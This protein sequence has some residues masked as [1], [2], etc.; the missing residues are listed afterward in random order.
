MRKI[1]YI[2]LLTS[3]LFLSGCATH[4]HKDFLQ[5]FTKSQKTDGSRPRVV[6]SLVY[7]EKEKLLL[8]G[9]E[10]GSIEIWDA[11]KSLSMR[12]IKAHDYRANLLAFS[13][14]G[15]AFFSNSYFE[16]VTKLWDVQSGELICSIPNTRGPVSITSDKRFHVI[17]NGD[18]LRIFDSGINTLLAESYKFPFYT[19][20]AIAY[21]ISTDQVAI[22]TDSGEIQ[23]LRF[24]VIKG[25]PT[26][27]KVSNAKP[28]PMGNWVVG[29][30]FSKS[31]R[32]L[33]SVARFGS[34]DEWSTQPFKIKRSLPIVLKNVH[35]VAFMP[36]KG[37]LALSGTE[38]QVFPGTDF[39]FVKV[40]PL[41]GGIPSTFKMSMKYPGTIE[42]LPPLASVLSAES[43][44][45]EVY[46]LPR[47]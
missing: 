43:Y 39:G 12:E 36:S 19:I 7:N 9:H 38:E 20:T 28:Y 42:F 14:D 10:S 44:S 5:N 33:Y 17:A 25:R 45:M 18:E 40:I 22:G 21:D 23:I 47:E 15:K 34:I 27:E 31:G 8:V 35:A 4:I 37:L 13:A 3:L 6:V 16:N 41:D 46:T 26:L 29:L 1:I 32:N 30:Q 11:K 24:S 2:A